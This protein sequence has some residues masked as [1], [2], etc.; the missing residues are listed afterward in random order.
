M[1]EQLIVA[2]LL[3]SRQAYDQIAGTLDLGTFSEHAKLAVGAAMEFYAADEKA[4]QV[5]RDL[6]TSKVRRLYP[7]EKHVRAL[8]DYLATI[9]REVSTPNIVREYRLL[10]RYT[11]G[12]H[13]AARLGAGEHDSETEKLWRRYGELGLDQ[14]VT[15]QDKLGY[16]DLVQTV[17]S[18]NKLRLFPERLN[19]AVS[20]GVSKGH[21]I[22]L[23]G[24]P[25][26]GKTAFAINLSAGF[27]KQGLRVLY[28]GNEEPV[29]D[30]QKRFLSRLSRIPISKIQADDRALQAS[31]QRANTQGYTNLVAKELSSCRVME[32]EAQVRKFKPDVLV[33][34]QLKN[35]KMPGE[36]N[37]A[38]EL[39]TVAREVR[40]LGKAY[41][42]VTVSVTQAGESGEGKLL[43]GQTDIEWSNTGIPGAAD[44]LIGIGVDAQ[45]DITGR[46]MIHLCKNKISGR[47]DHFPLFFYPQNSLFTSKPRKK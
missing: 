13:L 21:N 23:F 36:G 27:L 3:N 11:T 10:Q 7:N 5:D 16:E 1:E 41:N 9:P 4:Q 15:E 8:L 22:T 26:S 33:I 37:R 43:L 31:I 6:L 40:R 20:G 32:V 12:L 34:D 14:E 45:W 46:R 17:G 39:D 19:E 35:L 28:T 42:M 38:L 25:E 47:H 2:A 24:R 18:G 29:A 44:L 30:L